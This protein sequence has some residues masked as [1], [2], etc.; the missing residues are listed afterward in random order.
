[1]EKKK[2]NKPDEYEI[3]FRLLN[4][5]PTVSETTNKRYKTHRNNTQPWANSTSA[6]R[7]AGSYCLLSEW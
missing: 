1:M 3:I 4:G 6:S 5:V 2:L 7:I